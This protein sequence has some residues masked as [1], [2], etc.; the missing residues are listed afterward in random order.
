MGVMD[1]SMLIDVK[2]SSGHLTYPPRSSRNNGDRAL[3]SQADASE[4]YYLPAMR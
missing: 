3:D 2:S 1:R 4:R